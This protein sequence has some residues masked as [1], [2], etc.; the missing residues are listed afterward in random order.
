MATWHQRQNPHPLWHS[1]KW[2]AVSDKPNKLLS[3][4]RFDTYEECKV[5]CDNTGD[6]MIPPTKVLTT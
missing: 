2:T 3:V 4:M 6:Y 5:Y 1:T